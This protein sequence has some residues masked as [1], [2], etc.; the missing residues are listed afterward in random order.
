M[1]NLLV[2]CSTEMRDILNLICETATLHHWS[3][4]KNQLGRADP[5]FKLWNVLIFR[6]FSEHI[7][8][9]GLYDKGTICGRFQLWTIFICQEMSANIHHRAIYTKEVATDRFQLLAI[10]IVGVISD[11]IIGM[12]ND[13]FTNLPEVC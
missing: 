3:P 2:H 4:K 11:Y 10:L 12:K 5:K 9:T 6:A 13:L 8:R 7:L 1:L